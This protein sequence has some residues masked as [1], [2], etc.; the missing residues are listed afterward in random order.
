MLLLQ[1]VR[2]TVM[3]VEL[4]LG[5]VDVFQTNI[6]R[7]DYLFSLMYNLIDYMDKTSCQWMMRELI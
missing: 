7:N 2:L 4:M 5:V 3:V 1:L 6:L